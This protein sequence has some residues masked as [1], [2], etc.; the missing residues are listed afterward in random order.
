MV[1]Y[2]PIAHKTQGLAIETVVA[3]PSTTKPPVKIY[4]QLNFQQGMQPCAHISQ[5]SLSLSNAYSE[6]YEEL[7]QF[8]S[9]DTLNYMGEI[10]NDHTPPEIVDNLNN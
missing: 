1:T 4:P 7:E 9:I 3:T 10:V 6:A 2:L 5:D 8:E